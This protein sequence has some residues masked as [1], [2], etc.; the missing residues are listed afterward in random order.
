MSERSLPPFGSLGSG[1]PPFSLVKRIAGSLK[2]RLRRSRLWR[3]QPRNTVPEEVPEPGPEL[4]TR[5]AA[6]IREYAEA[7]SAL[8]ERAERLRAR[9]KRLESEGTPSDSAHN[10]AAR[11]EGEVEAGLTQ[12]RESFAGPEGGREGYI[13]FDRE[14]QLRYPALKVPDG[15]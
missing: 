6:A 4:R 14:V 13:A 1:F 2:S 9:S 12:L 15:S 5:A 10:R 3:A 11:A 8:F 7:H